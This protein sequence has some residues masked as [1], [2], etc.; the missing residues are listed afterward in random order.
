MASHAKA[1]LLWLVVAMVLVGTPAGAIGKTAR[2][3][4]AGDTPAETAIC[5]NST[6]EVCGCSAG[7]GCRIDR[8]RPGAP[9]CYCVTKGKR[10]KCMSAGFECHPEQ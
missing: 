6:G 4:G 3:E 1:K 7:H 10:R 2:K 5:R 8:S 9:S